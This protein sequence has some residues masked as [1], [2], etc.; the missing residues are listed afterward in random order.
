LF[1][2]PEAVQKIEYWVAFG[3]LFCRASVIACGDINAIVDGMF[4]NAAIHRIAVDAAL[5]LS[6]D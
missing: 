3:W 6:G 1:V 4:E 5:R 2:I